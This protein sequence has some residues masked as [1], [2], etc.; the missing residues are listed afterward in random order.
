ML[1]DNKS[2]LRVH[3]VS[4]KF[5]SLI[6]AL[7]LLEL[8]L[9]ICCGILVLLVLRHQVVHVAL[10]LGELH[11]VHAFTRV[12]VQEGLAPEHGSEL[13]RDA[14][15]QLLDGGAVANEGGRHLEAP[16]RDVTHGRLDVVG[17]PLHE[18]AAVLVLHIEHLLVHLFHG[19]AATEDGS[20]GQVAAMARVTGGHHILGVEHLL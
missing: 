16:G 11:L 13:L 18:V 19:H 12:P 17:D 1:E 14:L 20:H 4:E 5:L 9:L 15:E 10:C 6:L 7:L 8:A 3:N 2:S